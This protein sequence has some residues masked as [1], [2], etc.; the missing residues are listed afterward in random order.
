[1]ARERFFVVAVIASSIAVTAPVAASGDEQLSDG[2]APGQ[3]IVGFDRDLS[4]EQRTEAIRGEDA[5]RLDKLPLAGVE[6][7]GVEPG[8]S[9]ADAVDEFEQRGDVRYAQPDY[10]VEPAAFPDDPNIPSQWALHNAGQT[11][12][13]TAGTVDA[14]I[15]APEAWDLTTG[16]RSVQVAVIDTGIALDHP[17]LAANIW[18]N[19]GEVAANG[20][21][22]DNNGFVDDTRGW[23]FVQDDNNP[24]DLNGHGTHSAG[25]VGAVGNNGT[26]ISGVAQQVTLMPVRI[27]G[28]QGS[29]LSSDILLGMTYAGQNGAAIANVSFGISGQAFQDVFNQNPNTLYTLSAGNDGAN[30]DGTALACNTPAPNVVCVAASTQSDG[31]AGFSNFG[32]TSVELAAPGV[33][34]LSTF[35]RT[36]IFTDSF[37]DPDPCNLAAGLDRDRRLVG[38][39]GPTADLERPQRPRPQRLVGGRLRPGKPLRLRQT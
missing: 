36:T 14:D 25:N 16:S 13:G 12:N 3:L 38:L 7:V 35:S 33:N 28:V 30:A 26:L 23:D 18:T 29:G 32:A 15:D 4:R 39:R 24:Y 17:D 1:M 20:V 22:D 31:L 6:L 27:G 19:P 21:D 2:Y 10:V 11:V 8:T 9:V 37:N 5:S 34:N